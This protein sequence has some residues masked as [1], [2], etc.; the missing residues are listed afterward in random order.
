MASFPAKLIW[1]PTLITHDPDPPFPIE[2]TAPVEARFEGEGV[3]TSS[4]LGAA[5]VGTVTSDDDGVA[6][7]SFLSNIEETEFGMAGEA[8]TD[9]EGAF[10]SSPEMFLSGEA[11]ASFLG[12][13][14]GAAT[15]ALE[16]VATA[17]FV[18]ARRRV[19][20]CPDAYEYMP[21]AAPAWA[22]TLRRAPMIQVRDLINDSPN[23]STFTD[24]EEPQLGQDVQMDVEGTGRLMGGAV[25]SYEVRGDGDCRD[26]WAYDTNVADYLW[27]LNERRPFMCFEDEP[28][29]EAI[30]A[31]F[32]AYAPPDFTLSIEAGMPNVT[33]KFNGELTFTECVSVICSRVN[34]QFKAD[35]DKVLRV[36]KTVGIT[37]NPAIV[38]DDN[39]DLIWDTPPSMK[40]DAS[41]IRNRVYVK[42]A[43]AKV[44]AEAEAGATEI[45]VDGIDIFGTSGG[46]AII[47]CQRI[48]Y[49]GVLKTLVYPPTPTELDELVKSVNPSASTYT[50][51][52]PQASVDDSQN[53]PIGTRVRY[54]VTYVI[55][56]SETERGHP[57]IA[58]PEQVS[59]GV[60]W[61]G[62]FPGVR[63]VVPGAGFAT[64]DS[65]MFGWVTSDGKVAV[66]ESF[67]VGF[68]SGLNM[69]PSKH[70]YGPYPTQGVNT[71][72]SDPRVSS[73]RLWR[74]MSWIDSNWHEVLT[75]PKGTLVPIDMKDYESL[76]GAPSLETSVFGFSGDRQNDTGSRVFI[77]A[78]P[79]GPS[80]TTQRRV[81]RE[82]NYGAGTA[83]TT[84]KVVMTINGN[85]SFVGPIEDTAPT[86]VH[87]WSQAIALPGGGYEEPPS[88][89]T[90][91]APPAPKPKIRLVL[92]GV[93]GLNETAHEGDEVNIFTERNDLSAQMYWAQQRGGNGIRE[94][95]ITDRNLRSHAELIV[96]GDAEL[97][98][99]S[100]PIKT[101]T[102]STRD[103]LSI[104][105][106][107][108]DFNLTAP[109]IVASLR[110]QESTV[111]QIHEADGL[112]QRYTCV[113]SSV[114][115]TL[116]DL[117]RR[118]LIKEL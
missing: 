35:Y 33:V 85:N 74:K 61:A 3:A 45:E 93:T 4:F 42:G 76:G 50:P 5:I 108:V 113:A 97:T 115:F 60:Q 6:L 34:A 117:L 94:Y 102:Y 1:A 29:H 100:M 64:G 28:A 112:S 51:G 52:S 114:K 13:S 10:T 116:E 16:G 66:C 95:T 72:N 118:A 9:F 89:P 26:S 8:V 88:N 38:D 22:G 111:D 56:G 57:Y 77:T 32:A 11:T 82:E 19:A 41:Q 63:E 23:S 59:E 65:V 40:I 103:D 107:F 71:A 81:W 53:G 99:F 91:P 110:I 73:F 48:T 78:V 12:E 30:A 44:L 18:G 37:P 84:P 31:L 49:T 46:T 106:A 39:E 47:G 14:V 75:V 24:T 55:N 90:T 15:F 104:S 86:S 62:G 69:T 96:R 20:R 98:L 101:V 43:G 21:L 83:W 27:L 17:G 80:G 68:A 36:S 92:T 58:V 54:T 70:I 105:G 79:T 2:D 25:Q 109:P 7:T 67:T 87:F